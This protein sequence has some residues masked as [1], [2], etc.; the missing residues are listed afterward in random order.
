MCIY[1]YTFTCLYQSILKEVY[2]W[3][4]WRFLRLK[5]GIH[6][7]ILGDLTTKNRWFL[8]FSG[9]SVMGLCHLDETNHDLGESREKIPKWP[10]SSA[11]NSGWWITII[12]P[13]VGDLEHLDYFSI[14]WEVHH[15][16]WRT[17]IFQRG[18][19]HPPG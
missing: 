18:W 17:H 7:W 14:Y 6:Q 13:L 2:K 11:L 9:G 12:Q 8:C 1:I 16:N 19:N 10:K 3:K 4:I 5:I 15:P